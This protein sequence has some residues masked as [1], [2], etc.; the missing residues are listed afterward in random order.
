LFRLARSVAV[1]GLAA[2]L[3]WFFIAPAVNL[4]GWAILQG[5]TVAVLTLALHRGGRVAVA[6]ALFVPAIV[7]ATQAGVPAWVYLLAF[8]LTYSLGRNAWLERVPLYRS[9]GEVADRLADA[10]PPGAHLLEAGSGDAR[11]ALALVRRR[12]DVQVTAIENALGSCA[13]AWVRWLAAGRPKRLRL[14]CASF[15]PEDWG[16]YDAVYVF[17]SPAPMRRVWEKFR[18]QAKSGALL[19]S[20]TFE[21]PDVAPL[22]SVPLHGRLQRTLLFW[23]ADHG[24]E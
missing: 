20:N 8:V 6:H 15:W 11:L 4:P 2:L 7:L 24:N 1:Q 13:L 23:C 18:Q 21:V 12:Q 19:I 5:A 17:L 9:A 22:R 10:L 16:R 3:A 14:V